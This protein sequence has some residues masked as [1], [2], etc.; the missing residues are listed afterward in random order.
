MEIEEE[1]ENESFFGEASDKRWQ[2]WQKGDSSSEG[3][4]SQWWYD[5]MHRQS[6][7]E[8]IIL[9]NEYVRLNWEEMLDL[10]NIRFGSWK[11]KG[12]KG[13]KKNNGNL[14]SVLKMGLKENRNGEL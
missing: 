9:E 3:W 5:E 12:F 2:L 4:W 6:G 10:N 11:N 8:R 13:I 7:R 14:I 1:K